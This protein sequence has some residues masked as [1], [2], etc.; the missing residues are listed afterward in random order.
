MSI[1]LR[2]WIKNLSD[3]LVSSRSRRSRQQR[4]E[5]AKRRV[6]AKPTIESL[7]DRITPANHFVVTDPNGMAG[8]GSAGDVTL[9]YAV[10]N[11]GSNDL[12]GDGDTITFNLPA[13]TTIT[14][15][16]TL[17]IGHSVTITGS[18]GLVISGGSSVEVFNIAATGGGAGWRSACPG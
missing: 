12:L 2:S 5:G 6:S 1:I 18:P 10:A 15:N 14:L 4:S 11:L 9:P 16:A 17:N 8:S 7:E 3:K 13:S